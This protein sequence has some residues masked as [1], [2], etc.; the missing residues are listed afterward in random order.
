MADREDAVVHGMEPAPRE[1]V[2]DRPMADAERREPGA[3][4]DP[5]PARGEP[6]DHRPIEARIRSP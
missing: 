5:V 6:R 1:P 2:I 4:H 3:R